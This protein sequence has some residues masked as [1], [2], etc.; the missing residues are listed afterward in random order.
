MSEIH[1]LRLLYLSCH[2]A[3]LDGTEVMDYL[4]A[5][6]QV[7]WLEVGGFVLERVDEDCLASC[8]GEVG[9]R[10]GEECTVCDVGFGW[11]KHSM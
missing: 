7:M 11:G 6:S 5:V 4:L 8:F 1:V 3:H 2:D 10:G 9:L